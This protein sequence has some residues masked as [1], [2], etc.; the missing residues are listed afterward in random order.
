VNGRIA[1]INVSAGGVPKQPV[2]AARVGSL[3]LTADAHRDRKRHGGPERAL[4]LF[5]MELID[6]LACEGH[7][8]APGAIGENITVEGVPWETM[9][10]GA[11]YR[12]GDRVVIEV[13]A[14]TTPCLNIRRHFIGHHYSRVSQKRHPGWSRV[15][16]RVLAIGEIRCGDP[17][18]RLAEESP[19]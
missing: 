12:L 3:G 19:R 9:A 6:A 4:C 17:V 8:I 11:R 5:S 15:Y 7:P 14:Y 16:A 2:P 18:V 13:T 1:S 10:P